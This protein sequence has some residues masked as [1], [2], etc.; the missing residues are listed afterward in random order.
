MALLGIVC[1]RLVKLSWDDAI[2]SLRKLSLGSV[3]ELVLFILTNISQVIR[4]DLREKP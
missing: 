1:L 2:S 4:L 3:T